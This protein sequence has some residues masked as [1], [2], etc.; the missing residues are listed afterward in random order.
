[1]ETQK[2]NT[3]DSSFSKLA[4]LKLNKRKMG[5]C[6]VMNFFPFIFRFSMVKVYPFFNQIEPKKI[7]KTLS[8]F[9]L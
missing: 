5:F 8:I 3:R 6:M 2:K 7:P 9:V 1:M 4:K